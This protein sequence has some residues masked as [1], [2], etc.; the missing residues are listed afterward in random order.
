MGLSNVITGASVFLTSLLPLSCHHAA[1]ATKAA[2]PPS[3]TVSSTNSLHN[4]GELAL[5]NH[6]ETCIQLG[7]GADCIVLPKMLDSHTVELTLSLE[8][9]NANGQPEDLNVKQVTTKA[10]KPVEIAVGD[11]QL[12]L[13]PMVVSE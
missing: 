12:S 9:R 10:G 11:F 6:F 1:P 2:P 5:T 8:S 3:A 7:G 13:T 4:L